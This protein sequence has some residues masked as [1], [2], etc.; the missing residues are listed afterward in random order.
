MRIRLALLIYVDLNHR[1]DSAIFKNDYFY[2]LFLSSGVPMETRYFVGI[3]MCSNVGIHLYLLMP[4]MHCEAKNKF[5]D[6]LLFFR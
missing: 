4:S 5:N 2:F 1:K 3:D 6:V